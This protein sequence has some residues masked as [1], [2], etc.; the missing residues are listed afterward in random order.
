MKP[1]DGRIDI[2]TAVRIVKRDIEEVQRQR[3][4]LLTYFE[5]NDVET[6]SDNSSEELVKCKDEVVRSCQKKEEEI[7]L[8][9]Q[10]LEGLRKKK[11]DL[12]KQLE[13]LSNLNKD[14]TE[15]AVRTKDYRNRILE[16]IPVELVGNE[17]EIKLNEKVLNKAQIQ[18]ET[19]EKEVKT[20]SAKL[21][22]QERASENDL[23]N[24]GSGLASKE[25]LY[26]NDET[27]Y[28]NIG[29]KIQRLTEEIK[30]AGGGRQ[31]QGGRSAIDNEL[32]R[33]SDNMENLKDN[34]GNYND[35]L[36]QKTKELVEIT[37]QMG[38]N[39][40]NKVTF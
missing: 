33:I 17:T 36:N 5:E 28:K 29:A 1:V 15:S 26:M 11:E 6:F 34:L 4:A 25:G 13:E 19:W 10:K 39:A 16:I 8:V 9:D 35:N 2:E 12:Q 14:S 23:K 20:E 37:E 32:E 31:N 27:E 40:Q 22:E 3:D 18:L 7:V 38:K 21:E 24:F 30:Q